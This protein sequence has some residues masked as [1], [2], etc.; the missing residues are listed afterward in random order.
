MAIVG[1]KEER[2]KWGRQ[3]IGRNW[4]EGR[5]IGSV[6]GR[7][8]IKHIGEMASWWEGREGGK[9]KDSTSEE[10]GVQDSVLGT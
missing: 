3:C 6:R 4:S 5:C 2:E 9:G 10:T 8:R 1:G 7:G